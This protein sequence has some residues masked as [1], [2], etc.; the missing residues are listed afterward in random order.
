MY[1]SEWFRKST[2]KAHGNKNSGLVKIDFEMKSALNSGR[3]FLTAVRLVQLLVK[4]LVPVLESIAETALLTSV[5]QGLALVLPLIIVGAIAL[6]ILYLPLPQLHAC[7]SSIWGQNW[8]TLCCL[9]QQSSFSIASL[10]ALICISSSYAGAKK[11]LSNRQRINPKVTA[12]IC[13]ACYFV[14]V[15]PLQGDLPRN[16]FSISSGGFP[17]ALCT[18]T[19]GAPLFLFFLRRLHTA[20]LFRVNG[21]EPGF[22]DALSAVPAAAVTI[23]MFG[24]VRLWLNYEGQGNLHEQVQHFFGLPFNK[25]NFNLVS[26]MGYISL[27]QILWFFGIHGPN[28]LINVESTILMPAT[29]ENISAVAA[30]VAPHNILTKPFFDTFVHIGGSGATLS[31][32]LAILLK[33]K[34]SS[35]RRLALVALL[36][37]LFNV[38]EIVLFGLPLVLNPIYAIPFLLAPIIQLLV[39]FTIT[40]TGLVPTT[41]ANIHWTSPPLLGGYSATGSIIGALLQI[42]CLLAGTLTY[43]PFVRLANTLHGRSFKKS[44]DTICQTVEAEESGFMGQKCIDLPGQAGQLARNLA[45]DLIDSLDKDENVFLAYQPQVDAAKTCPVP[46]GAEALLRWRHPIY[47]AIPPHVTVTLAEEMDAINDLTMMVLHKACLKQMDLVENGYTDAVISVNMPPIHFYD[48]KLVDKVNTILRK[49]GLPP[50]LL[51]IEVTETMALAADEQPVETLRRLREMNIKVAIDD[52]G[53]GHTSLRYIKEFPVQTVKIDRSLTQETADGVNDHIVKSIVDLC[54]AL[55]IQ[56]IVEGVETEEQLERFKNHGCSI[57]QGYLFSKPL[58]EKE[59]LTYFQ[60]NQPL[61]LVA[62]Q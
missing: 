40:A 31:L 43:L 21:L 12:V 26:G 6:L 59:Y 13:L 10:A 53:M 49:T 27:S 22:Q 25:E 8:Q 17:L 2:S 18:A 15:V 56:I 20:K 52:F 29:L 48:A 62:N 36:P 38:N 7:L 1:F 54:N 28:L 39:A 14:L 9:V 5:R 35:A 44:M 33:G 34:D 57:F 46:V 58:P 45:Y 11:T 32:I 55:D 23:C 51:K 61:K 4:R 47:G 24:L 42:L 3:F 37:A 41:I 19:V 16:L 50:H 30:G 60:N